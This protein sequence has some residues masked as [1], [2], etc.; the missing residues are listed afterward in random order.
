MP[1]K[2]PSN[3]CNLII[4]F[5]NRPPVSLEISGWIN[6]C[7]R[8]FNCGGYWDFADLEIW[9]IWLKILSSKSAF[10]VENLLQHFA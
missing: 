9:R 7:S 6:G 2:M 4:F 8:P 3:N 1:M 10:S 5:K